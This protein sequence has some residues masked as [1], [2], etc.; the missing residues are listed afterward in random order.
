MIRIIA[1]IYIFLSNVIFHQQLKISFRNP[2]RYFYSVLRKS[3]KS[4]SPPF[5][6]TLN[7]FMPCC[8]KGREYLGP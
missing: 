2:L 8:R 6:P 4:A 7:F 5:L 3:L 1:I